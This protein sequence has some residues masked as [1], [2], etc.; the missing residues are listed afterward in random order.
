MAKIASVWGLEIG[1]SALKALKCRLDGETVVAEAF[2]YIEYP[3]ILSQPEAEPEALVREALETF[4]SRNDLKRCKVGI[5]VPGQS[6]L[7]KFFKPPPVELKKIPDIV[8]YEAKQQIPF[9]L[10]DVIWDYQQMAG[11]SVEDGFALETEVGLFAMKRDAV[12]RAIKPLQ[13]QGVE[14]DLIQLAPL[15]IYN[16]ITYDRLA[17]PEAGDIFDAEHPPKSL[18]VLAMGTDAT[19]LIITNGYRVWQ[20]NMPLGGNHFTRQLTKDLKLTFAKAEHLKRNAMEA[21][22]PKLVFQAMRPVFTDMVNEVQRSVGFFRSLNKKAELSSIVM[23]GNTTKLP[24][25]TNYL[26]KNLGMDVEV[27]EKFQKLTGDDILMA[28]AFKDHQ[29]A[30]GPVY[31]LCLQLL[32]LGPAHTN[33]VPKEIVK[34]RMIKAKKPWVVATAAALLLGFV[35]NLQFKHVRTDYVSESKWSSALSKAENTKKES[36]GE[37]STDAAKVTTI[38]LLTKVGEEVAGNRDRRILWMELLQAV[39]TAAAG[40]NA[41]ATAGLSPKELPYY[42]R[43]TI[44]ITRWDCRYYEDL[45]TYYSSSVSALYEEDKRTREDR[46]GLAKAPP[47]E[48]DAAAEAPAEETADATATDATATDDTMAADGMAMEGGE[49]GEGMGPGWVIQINAHHF[50]NQPPDSVKDSGVNYLTTFD[51]EEDFVLKRFIHVLET[52]NVKL[53]MPPDLNE[54]IAGTAKPLEPKFQEFTFAQLGLS[55]PFVLTGTLEENFAFANPEVMRMNN[56]GMGG[57]MGMGMGSDMSGL[58]GGMPGGMPGG[59]MPG[60]GM[61][62]GGM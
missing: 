42:K 7:A 31:G 20:R 60:G 28:P 48:A 56:Q 58:S 36:D 11:G 29:A 50:H 53:A 32:G 1:Q 13:A 47:P 39:M 30:F 37:K 19:D 59:G 41:N 44:H 25:L 9:D 62:G 8:K 14:I 49:G 15:S 18:V 35:I 34:A 51:E 23:L 10:N 22:D 61:P 43:E 6:G 55:K 52:G 54:L 46:L 12:Y 5:S 40:D 27:M 45:S 16:M 57:G 17:D 38:G 3:K 24:G 4:M 33:L 21:E 2:D 26:N